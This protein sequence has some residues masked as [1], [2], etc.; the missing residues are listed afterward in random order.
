VNNDIVWNVSPSPD[1]KLFPQGMKT[2]WIKPGRAV[3]KYLDGGEN[4]LEEMQN[5]TRLAAQLGFEYHVIEG[6]WRKWTMEQLKNFVAESRKQGVAI[7][8]W[9]HSRELQDP[10]VRRDFFRMC[11]EAGVAGSKIDFFDHE[12]KDVIELYEACLRDA[13]EFKQV[14]NFHGANKPTGESRMFPNELTREAVRGMESRRS[15]RAK[16]DAT[17]PFTRMLAGHA[18]YTPTVF[19][20]RRNDTTWAHQIA[21]AAVFTSPMLIYGGHPKS[22]LENPA[23]DVIRAIPSVWDETIALPGSEIG[24]VAAF[25][26]RRGNLWIVAVLNGEAARTLEIPLAFLGGGKHP[27]I[28]VRDEPSNAAALKVERTEV[29]KGDVWKVDLSAG[30]GFVAKIGGVAR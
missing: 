29:S 12:H 16:H 8:L 28:L 13:A 22:F 11:S 25:A 26:R 27:A 17:L 24:E 19:T 3:W 9:R 15:N 6:H 2:P 20:E 18:D 14:V 7:V 5:F 4:T 23:V 30:G 21:T 1:P 10:K